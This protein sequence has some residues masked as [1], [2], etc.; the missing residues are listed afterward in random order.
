[1]SQ[2]SIDYIVK[3][4]VIG[5]AGVG[6]TTLLRKLTDTQFYYNDTPTIGVDFFT[7][8]KY[9]NGSH[10]RINIW[11]TAGHERYKSLVKTY[12]KNN[13]ICYVVYDV[14]NKSSFKSVAMWINTFRNN[15]S[16]VNSIIVILAN[17]I[18]DSSKRVVTCEEGKLLADMNDAIYIEISSKASINLDLI[19][20]EPITKL[21]NL[22]E[23]NLFQPSD[24]SGFKV[25][26]LE[27]KKFYD[28]NKEKIC[29][30]VQ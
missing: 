10:V 7:L 13:A 17:K 8:N 12:F 19:I 2:K 9:I 30:I 4:I 27:N 25:V 20:T 3:T 28:S 26:K 15:T 23:K 21:L 22:Y 24:A 1:M 14:C 18:D 5:N 29:C 16:N 6:K 11:D